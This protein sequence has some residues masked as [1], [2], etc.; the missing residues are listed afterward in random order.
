M[1]LVFEGAP[2]VHGHCNGVHMEL[3]DHG[4]LALQ[5]AVWWLFILM[6]QGSH[7]VL[8]L[9]GHS[10]AIHMQLMDHGDHPQQVIW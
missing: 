6:V 2:G 5:P 9:G 3:T 7:L 4:G 1:A 10:S 8:K